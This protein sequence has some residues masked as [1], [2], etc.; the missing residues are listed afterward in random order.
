MILKTFQESYYDVQTY[1]AEIIKIIDLE[2]EFKEKI[3]SFMNISVCPPEERGIDIHHTDVN[4]YH[5]PI[6]INKINNI[7]EQ[8]EKM[9]ENT[10]AVGTTSNTKYKYR[11]KVTFDQ[12]NDEK[13]PDSLKRDKEYESK[14]VDP[15]SSTSYGT[16]NIEKSWTSTQ[17]KLDIDSKKL[18]IDP[19]KVG[20]QPKKS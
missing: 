10:N 3:F 9:K 7:L 11:Q 13:N 18:Y 20:H 5:S 6:F 14:D 1:W 2:Y 17:K 15:S 12:S 16:V 4:A 19:K 8:T